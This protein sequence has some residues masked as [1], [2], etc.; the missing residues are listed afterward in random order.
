[1]LKEIRSHPSNQIEKK[2]FM[3]WQGILEIENI[4]IHDNFFDIGGNSLS[5]I[6]LTNYIMTEFNLDLDVTAVFEFPTI[7]KLSRLISAKIKE[8]STNKITRSL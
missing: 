1:V 3:I 4:S 7:H 5:V 8:Q 2:L 6:S